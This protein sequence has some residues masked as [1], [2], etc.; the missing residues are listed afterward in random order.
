MPM[1]RIL[2]AGAS[3]AAMAAAPALAQDGGL[4]GD[5]AWSGYIDAPVAQID[6]EQASPEADV[7][8]YAANEAD[9]ALA[10]TSVGVALGNTASAAVTEDVSV[11]VNNAQDVAGRVESQAQAYVGEAGP[12]TLSATTYGN[13][14]TAEAED[15]EIGM[16]N[17]QTVGDGPLGSRTLLEAAD[18]AE[19]VTATAVTGANTATVMTDGAYGVLDTVQSNHAETAAST[20]IVAPD[21]D[22]LTAVGSAMIVVN[23]ADLDTQGD[24]D[25]TGDQYNGGNGLARTAIQTGAT[26]ATVGVATITGN[27]INL[28][29]EGGVGTVGATQT[30]EG[31]LFAQTVIDTGLFAGQSSATVAAAGNS[32]STRTTGAASGL[33]VTQNNSGAVI[34]QALFTGDSGIAATADVSAYGNA[35]SAALCNCDGAMT[36]TTRQVN[37]GPI[38]AHAYQLANDAG[39]LTASSV[40]AGNT[41]TY[42]VGAP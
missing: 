34:G 22:I 16:N 12:V 21:A 29:N 36:A 1:H 41:A 35:V 39:A 11:Q 15:A 9:T 27:N 40:A 23:N 6:N 42:T 26:L 20:E 19:S 14:F 25:L 28:I 4:R 3:L 18:Y 8:G 24:A 10:V 7:W 32:V 13:T 37:S 33:D 30:N 38:R 17:Q 31:E 2:L 5:R